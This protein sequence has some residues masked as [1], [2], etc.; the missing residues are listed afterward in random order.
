[1]YDETLEEMRK[2]IFDKST[3]VLN[4][5]L[6]LARCHESV[7]TL[8][9]WTISRTLLCSQDYPITVVVG[10]CVCLVF[11]QLCDTL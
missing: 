11:L 1:M 3:R 6:S 7:D 9:M 8:S 5:A 10:T 4:P 2:Q